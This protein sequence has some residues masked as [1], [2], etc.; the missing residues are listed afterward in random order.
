M[1]PKMGMFGTM[2]LT[3][4]MTNHNLSDAE[5]ASQVGC[6]VGAV[7]K[8]RYRERTPRPEQM[9]RIH[10]ITAGAVTPNDFLVAASPE[11]A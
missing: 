6:S 1:F 9:R 4:Y 5:L 11:A 3:E 7:R 8:W 10:E 2:T